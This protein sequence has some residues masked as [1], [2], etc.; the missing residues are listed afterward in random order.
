MDTKKENSETENWVLAET[1]RQHFAMPRSTMEVLIRR[2][3]P[4]IKLGRNRRF[5][6]SEVENWLKTNQK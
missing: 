3:L 1:M 4:H 5:K 6:L 2:G